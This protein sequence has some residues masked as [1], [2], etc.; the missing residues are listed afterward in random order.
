MSIRA[1]STYATTLL[2]PSTL[3]SGMESRVS[4]NRSHSLSSARHTSNSCSFPPVL[5][6]YQ[7]LLFFLSTL[8]DS[9]SLYSALC[10]RMPIPYFFVLGTPHIQSPLFSLSAARMPIPSLFPKRYAYANSFSFSSARKRMPICF[11]CPRYASQSVSF[12]L[13][14]A[15]VHADSVLLCPQCCASACRFCTFLSSVLRKHMPIPYFLVLRNPLTY[16]PAEAEV[17]VG[18]SPE[19][20]RPD[21]YQRQD[22]V[23]L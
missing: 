14:I 18:Q 2:Y 12:V 17:N 11:L 1:E 22:M 7:F 23:L 15:Q 9:F 5:C 13:S 6:A 21:R 4:A 10:K 8:A 3:S 19:R 20:T 16:A